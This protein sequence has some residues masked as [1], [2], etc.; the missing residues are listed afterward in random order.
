[1]YHDTGVLCLYQRKVEKRVQKEQTI[2]IWGEHKFLSPK[3]TS[4]ASLV[5]G[6]R[7]VWD[8][9]AWFAILAIVV[10]ETIALAFVQAWRIQGLAHDKDLLVDV[11][12]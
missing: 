2:L 9:S 6:I 3:Y 1:M 10:K 4:S 11:K 12:A 8:Q 5:V 7:N